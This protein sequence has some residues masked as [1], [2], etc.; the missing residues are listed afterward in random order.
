MT[1]FEQ[2]ETASDSRIFMK[3][4]VIPE[5]DIWRAASHRRD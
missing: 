4:L 2:P 5:L 1:A 3:A